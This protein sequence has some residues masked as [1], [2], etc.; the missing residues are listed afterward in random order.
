MKRISCILVVL[1]VLL[2]LPAIGVAQD[3]GMTNGNGVFKLEL[4]YDRLDFDMDLTAANPADSV[5][6]IGGIAGWNNAFEVPYERDT[7]MLEASYGICDFMDIQVGLGYLQDKLMADSRTNTYTDHTNKG[8]SN[9]LW[10][11]GMLFNFIRFDSG[12]YLGGAASYSRW[13]SGDESYVSNP[14]TD[15]RSFETECETYAASLYAGMNWKQL[16]VWAGAEYTQAEIDQ[17]LSNYPNHNTT[18]YYTYEIDD[19]MGAV[20]GLTYRIN[21][22]F[23]VTARGRFINQTSFNLGVGYRF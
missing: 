18:Y 22:H 8:D 15:P 11:I 3:G 4:A 10:K 9:Y 7:V 12:L 2:T 19:N 6:S 14:P 20:A 16:S 17:T 1:A 5:A 23:D 13:D 21:D